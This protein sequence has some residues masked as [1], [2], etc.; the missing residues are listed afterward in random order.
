MRKVLVADALI[1]GATGLLLALGSGPLSGLLGLRPSLL[2]LAGLVLIP[3]SAGVGLLARSTPLST[4]GVRAVILINLLWVAG[5]FALLFAG[6]DPSLIGTLF[7]IVQA[8]VVAALA[9]A[10]IMLLR[11][12]T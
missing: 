9:T 7:V 11:S 2:L 12:A 4:S 6:L 1:S 10:Q 8:L 5:S 3:F